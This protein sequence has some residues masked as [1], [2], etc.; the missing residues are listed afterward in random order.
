M[1][2]GEEVIV[3]RDLWLI[4]YGWNIYLRLWE[5]IFRILEG[6]RINERF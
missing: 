5:F 6:D 3:L 2:S 1:G 4:N